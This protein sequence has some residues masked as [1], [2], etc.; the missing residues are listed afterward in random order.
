MVLPQLDILWTHQGVEDGG[1]GLQ[2]WRAWSLWMTT[3]RNLTQIM[4]EF[5]KQRKEKGL[6]W[7]L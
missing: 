2:S 6:Y 1:N 4:F 7:F 3:N 5:L